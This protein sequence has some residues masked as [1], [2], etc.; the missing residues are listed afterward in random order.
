MRSHYLNEQNY[1]VFAPDVPVARRT[2]L[3]ETPDLTCEMCGIGPGQ[4]DSDTGFRAL[5]HAE[6]VRSKSAEAPDIHFACSIC[7][8]GRRE[9]REARVTELSPSPQICQADPEDQRVVYEW[10]RAKFGE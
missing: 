7:L 3:L 8:E 6:L 4:I 10:L 9:M 2:E 5:V 1:L